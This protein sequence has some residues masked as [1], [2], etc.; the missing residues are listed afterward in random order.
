[1]KLTNVMG[2]PTGTLF[3][4][5]SVHETLVASAGPRFVNVI[6]YV[7]SVSGGVALGPLFV[8]A[9]SAVFGGVDVPTLDESFSVLGSFDDETVAILKYNVPFAA[10]PGTATVSVNVCTS[11]TFIDAA[12]HETVPFAPTAGVEQTKV[13]GPL[14][15]SDTNVSPA[16][17]TSV[18]LTAGDVAS[19]PVSP[20]V[21]V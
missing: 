20:T 2:K 7:T 6:V 1:L 19:G 15:P 21:I 13:S 11:S 3:G 10:S 5:V 9:T 14:W 8:I 4:S 17:I 18:M 12:S 16:G